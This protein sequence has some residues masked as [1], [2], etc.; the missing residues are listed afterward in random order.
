MKIAVIGAGAL[1]LYYGAML[2]KGGYDVHFLLRSD[3][4]AIHDG[5]L[6][7]Y[8]INGDFHLSQLQ[9]Y[10]SSEQI[11]VVDVVI[12]GLKT[13]SNGDY[14][15]LLESLVGPNTTILTLQNGLGNEEQLAA[16][17]GA[18]K[19]MGGVAFLCS[20]RGEPGTVHHLGAGRIIV[21]EFAGSNMERAKEI[22]RMFEHSG[23]ECKA[24]DDLAKAR[25]EKLVWNIPF[26]GICALLQKPVDFLLANARLRKLVKEIMLEVIAGANASQIS[27]PLPANLADAMISFTENMGAYRP[28]MMID[29]ELG[30]PLELEAIFAIPLERATA[31]G[32]PMVRTEEL[33]DLLAAGEMY[34]Q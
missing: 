28:S 23:V 24:T 25:W 18:N 2:Q 1:G 7:I 19:I 21:G 11:G 22:A 34:C 4:Q 17:F 6:T 33:L 10:R 3:Y 5:G 26:N 13:F 20:N 32:V 27:Q 12:V 29:R 30:R 31:G 16:L 14:F 15:P 9:V 8:S